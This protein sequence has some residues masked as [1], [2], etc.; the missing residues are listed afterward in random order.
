MTIGRMGN[1]VA[2]SLELGMGKGACFCGEGLRLEGN[3]GEEEG[4]FET[5]PYRGMWW[6]RRFGVG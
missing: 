1:C 5:R 4:G 3:G 6:L 2:A